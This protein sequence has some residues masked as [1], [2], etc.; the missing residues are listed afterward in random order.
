MAP[1][2][3][4]KARAD[5]LPVAEIKRLK[6]A[7]KYRQGDVEIQAI[8]DAYDKGT[9]AEKRE[10]LNKYLADKT[11]SWKS[12]MSQ[13][14]SLN[15]VTKDSRSREWL[16]KKQIAA[17][18]GM[19]LEDP[20]LQV[21]LDGLPER[22]HENQKLAEMGVKQYKRQT[23]K[24]LSDDEHHEST[25]F[26][27]EVA[28]VQKGTKNVVAAAGDSAASKPQGVGGGLRVNWT[29]AV[30]AACKPMKTNLKEARGLLSKAYKFRAD[31]GADDKPAMREGNRILQEALEAAE[32]LMNAAEYSEDG[33][34]QLLQFSTD[35]SAT[36]T[37]YQD[38]L[39]KVLPKAKPDAESK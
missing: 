7:L 2:P 25:T 14:T 17:A 38:L 31:M 4:G 20:E 37:A 11:F 6:S 19:T 15:H 36:V 22:S 3:K 12:Q 18:E 24:E 10:I 26:S 21:I 33:H 13:A 39:F 28:G 29:N 32:D 8:N 34:R 16:T 23:Q 30:K 35:L 9:T 1:K 27:Q 5:T